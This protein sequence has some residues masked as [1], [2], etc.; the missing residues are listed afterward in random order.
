MFKSTKNG[1]GLH[2]T[3]FIFSHGYA[4]CLAMRVTL[5][6]K[7]STK[8]RPFFDALKVLFGFQIS[9]FNR[10]D[11]LAYRFECVEINLAH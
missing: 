8:S 7:R 6:K 3:F 11:V 4:R 10:F 2:E 1:L 5:Y 9:D